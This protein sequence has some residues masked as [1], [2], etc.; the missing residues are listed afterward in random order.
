MNDLEKLDL[1]GNGGQVYLYPRFLSGAEADRCFES[2]LKTVS[3]RHLPVKLFGREILQPRLSALF[4]DEGVNYIYSG[5][6]L[7]PEQWLEELRQL[8]E[9]IES[10]CGVTFN[11]ALL[12]LYRNGGDYMGWHRDNERSLGRDPV[13]ASISLGPTRTFQLRNYTTKKERVS[14]GLAHGDLLLMCGTTQTRWEHRLPKSTGHTSR[15]I[16]ITFRKIIP[17]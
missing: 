2:L 17:G 8:K 4:T 3:W 10:K 15:R 12:N 13:I 11:S 14:V 7:P 16:N 6:K 1:L 5:L 9:K